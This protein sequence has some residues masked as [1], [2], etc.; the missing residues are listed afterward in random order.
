M[1]MHVSPEETEELLRKFEDPKEVVKSF[2][3]YFTYLL[4]FSSGAYEV[5]KINEELKTYR[6]ENLRLRQ[7]SRE[8]KEL[9][10]LLSAALNPEQRKKVLK[11]Y[12]ILHYPNNNSILAPL[13]HVE[14]IDALRPEQDIDEL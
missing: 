6:E 7:E 11:A 4:R 9:I 12:F 8:Q 10:E 2:S 13:V 5:Q 3:D 14:A 1:N